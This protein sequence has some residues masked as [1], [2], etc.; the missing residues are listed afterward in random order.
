MSDLTLSPAIATMIFVLGCWGGHRYRQVWKVEGPT[1]KLW[2]YGLLAGVSFL[3]LGFIPL[4][5]V[6]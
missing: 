4:A 3:A 6:S 1:W 5:K 2:V